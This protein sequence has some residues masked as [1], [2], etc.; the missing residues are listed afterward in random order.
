MRRGFSLLETTFVVGLT[1][2][3]LAVAFRLASSF[4]R[5][6]RIEGLRSEMQQSAIISLARVCTDA[7][8]TQANGVSVNEAA[9]VAIAFN[10][11]KVAADGAVVDGAGV[12]SWSDRYCIFTWDSA[13][14]EFLRFEW[15]PTDPL[16]V[17]AYASPVRAK[18]LT[19]VSLTDLAT[20]RRPATVTRLA[21]EVSLFQV[22]P[23]GVGTL[24]RQPLQFTIEVERRAPGRSQ[25]LRFRYS[26]SAYLEGSE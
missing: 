26:R 4:L 2:L 17:A 3:L 20:A 5:V 16:E 18:R 22:L 19:P 7:S 11:Y 9:P 23:V 14:R 1:T 24:M 12:I 8:R 10:P 15:T 21:T 6:T 13:L 25:P